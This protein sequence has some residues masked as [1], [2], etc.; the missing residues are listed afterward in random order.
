MITQSLTATITGKGIIIIDLM[1]Y[2]TYKTEGSIKINECSETHISSI[3]QLIRDS[4]FK[5]QSSM[6]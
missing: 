2:S 5:N 3:K 6:I 1:L 4:Q